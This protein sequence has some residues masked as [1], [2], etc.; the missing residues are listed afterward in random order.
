MV[1]DQ[2][3]GRAA[4]PAGLPPERAARLRVRWLLAV[5]A[6]MI[7][8]TAG[9]PLVNS[10]V[11]DRNPIRPGTRLVV[12]PGNARSGQITMGRGWS[13][14]SAESRPRTG[15][16]LQHGKVHLGVDYVALEN[17]AQA[18]HLWSGLR[19]LLRVTNPG[20][21]LSQPKVIT[22][23]YGRTG[24]T[25]TV[26]GGRTVGTATIYADQSRD[27]AI[28]MIMLA[29]RGTR[30]VIFLPGLQIMRSLRILAGGS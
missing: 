11:S 3:T 16:S 19:Q 14:Q 25:G 13:L 30:H 9:W 7:V 20:L 26:S 17:P 6:V 23:R 28:E 8:L 15:Y 2:P 27:F 4:R 18:R 10:A 5:I 12:G 29:P 24:V 22:S 21:R 1:P